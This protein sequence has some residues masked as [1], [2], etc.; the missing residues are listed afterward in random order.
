ML[1]RHVASTEK[2]AAVALTAAHSLG[3]HEKALR[4]RPA[5]RVRN[6]FG[7]RRERRLGTL[8][9]SQRCEAIRLGSRSRFHCRLGGSETSAAERQDRRRAHHRLNRDPYLSALELQ[10]G[11]EQWLRLRRKKSPSD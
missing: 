8:D 4:H 7:S 11:R 3:G 9:R 1:Q 5:Q 2:T 6:L 10:K